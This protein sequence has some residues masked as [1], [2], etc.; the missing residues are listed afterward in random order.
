MLKTMS[1]QAA[2]IRAWA[3]RHVVGSAARRTADEG[4]WRSDLLGAWYRRSQRAGSSA[5]GGS[6]TIACFTGIRRHRSAEE[7]RA[8]AK[9][10]TNQ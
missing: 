4:W 2:G 6:E 5:T 3:Y 9:K 7:K 1:L 10:G 8:A